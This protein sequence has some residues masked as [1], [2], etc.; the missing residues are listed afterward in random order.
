[1]RGSGILWLALGAVLVLSDA[2][3]LTAASEGEICGGKAE[4]KCD[5]GLW[6]DRDEGACRESDASGTCVEVSG[7]CT[8]D[9]RPVCGCDGKTYGN[10][11]ERKIA[12][13]PRKSKGQ[14]ER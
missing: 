5:T 1:M 11:C 7:I 13:V 2:E 14:C 8:L 3:P 12:Q 10:D 9:Y 4:V 6:C